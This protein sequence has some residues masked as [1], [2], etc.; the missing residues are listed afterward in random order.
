MA[1]VKTH[2]VV[3]CRLALGSLLVSGVSQPAVGLKKDGGAKVFFRVPPV[4]RAGCRAAGAENAFVET[5]ELLAIRLALTE[6]SALVG[7]S[8]QFLA[9]G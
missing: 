3:Q 8:M 5:V 7:F 1:P 6:L 9:S 2:R 4:G